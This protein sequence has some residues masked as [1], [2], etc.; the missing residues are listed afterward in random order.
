MAARCH[1]ICCR[2]GGWEIRRQKD[3]GWYL[4][5]VRKKLVHAD[6]YEHAKIKF[7]PHIISNEYISSSTLY[8]YGSN[9]SLPDM[10]QTP[11]NTKSKKIRCLNS[12]KTPRVLFG[13]ADV[14]ELQPKRKCRT[15]QWAKLRQPPV[16]K[17]SLFSYDCFFVG[18]SLF[19]KWKHF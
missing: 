13:N 18:S 16:T 9:L 10:V 1:S 7:V 11:L 5:F 2:Q 15:T 4:P 6:L 8:N 14:R 12:W 19:N 3:T 17:Y